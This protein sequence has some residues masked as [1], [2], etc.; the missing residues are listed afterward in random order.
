MYWTYL[1]AY[2]ILWIMCLIEKAWENKLIFANL[3]TWTFVHFNDFSK[4]DN[5]NK[6]VRCILFNT[7]TKMIH[8]FAYISISDRIKE[9]Y[10]HTYFRLKIE[11]RSKKNTKFVLNECVYL[12]LRNYWKFYDKIRR[13]YEDFW[14]NYWNNR[15]GV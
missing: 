4:T 15:Y 2:A 10:S 14:V 1:I 3:Y 7:W 12:I 8:F 6:F 11:H 13:C 5:T 9:L